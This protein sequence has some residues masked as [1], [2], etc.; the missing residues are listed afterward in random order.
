MV[1]KEAARELQVL[2]GC[3]E[4]GARMDQLRSYHRNRNHHR[5][6]KLLWLQWMWRSKTRSHQKVK[7]LVK[8]VEIWIGMCRSRVAVTVMVEEDLQVPGGW[9]Q[10]KDLPFQELL[11]YS[12]MWMCRSLPQNCLFRRVQRD[13]EAV[14]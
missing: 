9:S 14:E 2:P 7:E 11:N 1:V 12:V 10:L 4:M 13:G 5:W 6:S 3:R 8:G